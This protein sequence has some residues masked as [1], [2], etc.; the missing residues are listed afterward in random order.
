MRL[1]FKSCFIFNMQREIFFVGH[2]FENVFDSLKFCLEQVEIFLNMLQSTLLEYLSSRSTLVARV[3]SP[4]NSIKGPRG[5]SSFLQ[6]SSNAGRSTSSPSLPLMPPYDSSSSSQKKKLK[7]RKK[8]IEDV[9]LSANHR[10]RR[11]H[12]GRLRRRR[13]HLQEEERN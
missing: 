6:S 9:T 2:V 10:G 7:K 13:G 11:C 5:S 1:S 4:K 3:L 12:Q 8:E